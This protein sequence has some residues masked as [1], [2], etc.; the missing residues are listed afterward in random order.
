MK[1]TT[2]CPMG[3]TR[4]LIR[5][6]L[7][8]NFRSTGIVYNS[9]LHEFVYSD[10]CKGQC[11]PRSTF[12]KWPAVWDSADITEVKLWLLDP[13]KRRRYRVSRAIESSLLGCERLIHSRN[14]SLSHGPQV[15]TLYLCI[16]KRH[17]LADV[18]ITRLRK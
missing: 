4:F 5:I 18:I 12:S 16:I 14:L 2:Q 11:Y 3:R 6:S 15:L 10:C 13:L 7:L 9:T 17:G 1:L 8:P